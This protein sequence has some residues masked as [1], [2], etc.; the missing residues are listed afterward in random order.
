MMKNTILSLTTIIALTTT[1]F[2]GGKV[3]APVEAPVEPIPATVSPWPL[4]VG[5]GAVASLINRDG[6][7]CSD[8]GNMK[9]R[10]FGGVLRAGYDFNK[11][12]GLEARGLKTF[13]SDAFSE[14]TH[15]GLYAKPQYYL[16]DSVN[17]YGLLGYGRTVVDYTNGI[18][19]SHN[20]KNG[21]AYGGGFEYDFGGE[22]NQGYT[23]DRAFD[24][25]GDQEKGWGLWFDFTHLLSNEGTMNTDSNIITTGVTFD[26]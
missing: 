1:S 25:Q 7:A 23:F 20:P 18:K 12:F 17:L 8:G 14:V 10:R 4:Y 9:D 24:G 22:D 19:N 15:Y 3:V 21:F 16:T 6:C 26:F 11:Y 5:I 2:A 13:G